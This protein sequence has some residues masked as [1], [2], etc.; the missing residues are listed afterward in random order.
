M[1][2]S[3]AMARAYSDDLRGKV[4]AAYA[5]GRGTFKELAERFG[6]SYGWVAK[7]YAMERRTGSRLR[8][9]QR[10]RG[11]Q[12]RIDAGLV[13]SLVKQRPDIVLR[14]L[15]Q[16]MREAGTVVS[17]AHLARVLRSLGLRLKKSRSTPP[18]ATPKPTASAAKPS[19][20]GSRRSR[21]KT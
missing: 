19:S 17:I 9:P 11:R 4:L 5:A 15:Q 13:R 2:D 16:Q 6:V 10:S 14:E 7:I 8:P 12:S 21:P 20:R 1:S 3:V 18:S